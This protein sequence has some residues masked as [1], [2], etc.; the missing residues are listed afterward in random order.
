MSE[1]EVLKSE[2][3]I[4]KTKTR[5]LDF[6][7]KVAKAEVIR[8]TKKSILKEARVE[9]LTLE[10]SDC[11]SACSMSELYRINSGLH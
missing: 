8:L 7:I 10:K 4:I 11:S 9:E 2:I 5:E 6:N 3:K 1:I